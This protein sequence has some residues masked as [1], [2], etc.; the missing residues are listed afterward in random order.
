[1]KVVREFFA[2]AMECTSDYT[3]FVRGK[4]VRYDAGTI[5]QLFQLPYN[6]SGPNEVDYLMNLVNMEEVS[7]AICKKRVFGRP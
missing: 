3:V 7:N 4:Q 1:M 5:N 6:P 2:N